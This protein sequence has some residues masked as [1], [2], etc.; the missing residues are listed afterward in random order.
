[1][2]DSTSNQGEITTMK[3]GKFLPS[4]EFASAIEHGVALVDFNAPWCR[5]C[6]AQE[7]IIKDI[8]RQFE[9][10]IIV[11]EVNVDEDRETAMSLVIQSIPTLILFKNGHE[12]QRFIG[13]Q[14]AETLSHA[15]E[16]ALDD[17]FNFRNANRNY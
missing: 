3:E 17:R 13:L 4:D 9:G 6:R 2:T 14:P 7:P 5:P 1:V 15:I 10:K 11:S 8:A 16:N 12:I